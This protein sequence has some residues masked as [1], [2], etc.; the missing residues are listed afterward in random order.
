MVKNIHVV[1]LSEHETPSAEEEILDNIKESIK[2]EEEVIP[3]RKPPTKKVKVEQQS[4]EATSS[5]GPKPKR[6]PAVRKIKVVNEEPTVEE[7]IVEPVLEEE[8]AKE[9][10]PAK[11]IKT[12]ELIQCDKCGKELTK[13]SLRY[14][15]EKNCPGKPINREELPVKRQTRKPNENE[16]LDVKEEIIQKEVE[17]RIINS[18]ESKMK[19]KEEKIKKLAQQIA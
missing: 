18:R 8:V 10:K 11:K 3:K 9:T 6:K 1:N 7:Q 2:Q 15:H 14:S 12:V 19:L 4:M 16:I 5:S 13:K 17:K